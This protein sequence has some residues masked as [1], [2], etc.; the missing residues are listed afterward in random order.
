MLG[1]MS[2]GAVCKGRE[3]EG[4]EV[5]AGEEVFA[6]AAGADGLRAQVAVG[7]GDELEVA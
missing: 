4:P 7:A 5:D 6:E 1:S 2:S 3:A